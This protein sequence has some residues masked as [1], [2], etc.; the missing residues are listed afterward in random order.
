MKKFIDPTTP[1]K[2]MSLEIHKHDTNFWGPNKD[3][4]KFTIRFTDERA[5]GPIFFTSS[6]SGVEDAHGTQRITKCVQHVP[7]PSQ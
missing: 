3:L 4:K 1:E 5:Y 7:T 2:N 6:L